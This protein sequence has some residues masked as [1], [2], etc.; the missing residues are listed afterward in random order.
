MV[1]SNIVWDSSSGFSLFSISSVVWVTHH[2]HGRKIEKHSKPEGPQPTETMTKLFGL[3]YE[4]LISL[5]T[6]FVG[7]YREP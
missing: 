4:L 2:P 7:N 6:C 1:L 5:T 3:L